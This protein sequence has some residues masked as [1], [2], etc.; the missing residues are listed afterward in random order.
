MLNYADTL[1]GTLTIGHE[2]GHTM[3]TY[4]TNRTQPYVYAYY[5]DFVA[6][7]ASTVNEALLTHHLLTTSEDVKVR[8]AILNAQISGFVGALFRQTMLAEFEKLAHEAAE[9]GES[10]T[11][12]SMSAIHYDLNKLYYGP[13]VVHDEL[14]AIEWAFMPHFYLNFMVY[15]YATGIAAATALSQQ[16]ISEGE[17]AAERYRRFLSSGNSL[18]S[19]DALREAGVDMSSPAPIAQAM[20]VFKQRLGELEGA[21]EREA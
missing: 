1:L 7:T 15:Q 6:E 16:I 5:S 14:I 13:D 12:D 10:L 2:L 20:G 3:H 17:P 19:I 8:L 11:A 4:Y 21:V 18:Y 9:R